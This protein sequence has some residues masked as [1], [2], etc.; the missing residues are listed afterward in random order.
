MVTCRLATR[1]TSHAPAPRIVR[2]HRT[3]PPGEIGADEGV[4]LRTE[5]WYRPLAD[6]RPR[7]AAGNSACAAPVVTP[8]GGHPVVTLM[9]GR[10][11]AAD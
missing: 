6:Q 3:W 8:P 2:Q 11:K 7:I 1:S 10:G 9:R 4:V 5:P